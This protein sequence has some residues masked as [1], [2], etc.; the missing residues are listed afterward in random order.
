MKRE[1]PNGPD[2][3]ISVVVE[4]EDSDGTV[5]KIGHLETTKESSEEVLE[6]KEVKLNQMEG[7]SV[8]KQGFNFCL[9]LSYM[10]YYHYFIF[11]F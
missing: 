5:E 10:Y 6:D 9:N 3:T 8:V 1:D 4:S 11:Y 7:I 2:T